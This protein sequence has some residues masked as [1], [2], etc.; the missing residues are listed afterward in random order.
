ML[1][2]ELLD[3]DFE[4]WVVFIHGIGGSTK[5]WKKQ[6][7]SFSQE[8]NLLMLDLP[9]HGQSESLP[10]VTISKVNELIKEVLDYE[11]IT[12]A[13]FVSMSLGT[14][15]AAHF[16]VKYPTMVKSLV[17]GGAVIHVD[18][19]HRGLM[20]FA[21]T[22]KKVIPHHIIYNIFAVIMMPKK[23]HKKSRKIFMREAKKMK[24]RDFIEWVGYLYEIVHPKNIINELKKLNI[25]MYFISG[26]QDSCFVQGVKRLSKMLSQSKMDL[27]KKCGHVC[28]IEKYQEF[29]QKVLSWLQEIHQPIP[30]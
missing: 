9:G 1:H 10:R 11:G 2:Y 3:N 30:A 29:N 20:K 8:Y 24:R 6:I 28:T 18:A 25:K 14:L 17:F 21:N 27:I 16:A 26:D 12:S 22:T 23:N 7:D 19:I 4:D 15:V 13:D 5:T